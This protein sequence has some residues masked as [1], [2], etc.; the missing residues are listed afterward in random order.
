MTRHLLVTAL[1]VAASSVASAKDPPGKIPLTTSSDEARELYIKARDLN[2]RLKGTD[3]HKLFE[4]AVAKDKNFAMAY[5]GLATTAGTTKEF[6]TAL[7]GALAV[8]TKASDAERLVIHALEAGAKGDVVH[9]KEYLTKLAS[10]YPGDERAQLQL[11]IFYFGQQDYP[12]AIEKLSAAIKIDPTFSAPYNQLGYAYRFLDKYAEAKQTFEKY[13]Q[14]IP[15]DPNPYDSYAE[16]LM[17]MGKFDDSI[18]SYKKAL[19]IDPNFVASLVGIGNDQMFLGKGDD[20]RKT[21]GQL[22]QRARSDGE[23]RQAEIWMAVSY[24]HEGSW[25]KALAEIDKLAAI[26]TKANDFGQLAFDYNFAAN[27]LL[28]ANRPD[29]AAKQFAA[30]LAA[31][32]KSTIPADAKQTAKRNGIYDDARVALAKHDVATAKRLSASYTAAVAQKGIPF[33]VRQGHE[34]AGMIASAEKSWKTAVVELA[35]ANQNDPRVLYLAAI[36]LQ[37]SGDAAKAKAMAVKAAEFNGLALNYGYVRTKAKE[38][39]R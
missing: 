31:S 20:A 35:Q 10:N 3:A 29:E 13:I 6:F 1:V 27:T 30:Q 12:A 39:A 14:L 25:D 18:A 9:Q 32:D 34:L 22:L 19:A 5:V 2:E 8:A 21:F 23:R 26:A 38:L 33:E 36:A 28:E 24:T 11:G 37:G 7:E 4:Q 15:D 16:L 17:K